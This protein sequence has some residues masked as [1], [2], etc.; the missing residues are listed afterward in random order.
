MESISNVSSHADAFVLDTMGMF[1]AVIA[2]KDG[3]WKKCFIIEKLHKVW[4]Q[5][6]KQLFL[7]FLKLNAMIFQFSLIGN[8]KENYLRA[9]LMVL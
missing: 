4:K 8:H 2:W 5:L 6:T 9:E 7:I 1:G 3:N